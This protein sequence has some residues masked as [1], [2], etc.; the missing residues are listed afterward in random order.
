MRASTA[1]RGQ[2]VAELFDQRAQHR[3]AAAVGPARPARATAALVDVADALPR[4]EA[5][6]VSTSASN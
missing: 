2:P 5:A 6:D 4:L 1:R 3:A